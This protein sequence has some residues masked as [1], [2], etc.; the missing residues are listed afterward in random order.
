MKEKIINI[1]N[2]ITFIRLI[3]I[4]PILVSIY[5]ESKMVI[6]YLLLALLTELDGFVA[7]KVKQVTHFGANFDV[8]VDTLLIFSA[9]IMFTVK[10]KLLLP[11][12]ATFIAIEIIKAVKFLV[13][14]KEQKKFVFFS[15]TLIGKSGF[16]SLAV[17]IFL[18]AIN[19]PYLNLFIGLT[20]AIGIVSMIKTLTRKK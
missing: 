19:V 2:S 7:K 20:I 9:L 10:G 17:L 11:Y 1:P 16:G 5:N 4:A 14:S 6:L 8:V 3:L 12:L 15:K 13:L 18:I